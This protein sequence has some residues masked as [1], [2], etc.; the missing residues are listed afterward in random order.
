MTS[1][2]NSPSLTPFAPPYAPVPLPSLPPPP[3]TPPGAVAR[4][5]PEPPSAAAPGRLLAAAGLAGL[6]A[7]TV[8]A[9]VRPG[10]GVPLV[11]LAVAVAVALGGATVGGPVAGNAGT[12]ARRLL[13]A[14]C[15]ILTAVAAVRDSAWLV[16]LCLLAAVVLA[17]VAV[18]GARGWA[19]TA[20]A[21][22]LGA[23]AFGSAVGWAR[24]G[25]PRSRPTV[26]SRAW[27]RGLAVGAVAAVVVGALLASADSAFADLLTT[28]S[29]SFDAGTLP[30]RA[31]LLALVALSVLGGVVLRAH[32]PDWAQLHRPTRAGVTAP[33]AAEWA[34]PLALVD[35]VLAA[36]VVLQGDL[37]GAAPATPDG[38]L[39]DRAR[40]GFGQLV[41]VTLLTT[42]LLVW[43]V[44][45]ASPRRSRH[46]LAVAVLGGGMVALTL[47]VV[48]SAL[49]RLWRYEQAYGW[50][51]LRLLVGLG[52]LWL[53]AVLL[54]VAVLWT[55][56]RLHLV[57][58]LV[59]GSAA[60]CLAAVALAG[61][62][63]LVARANVDRFADTGRVDVRY[64]QRLSADAVPELD[65]L[66]EPLRSCVLDAWAGPR[67]ADADAWSGT[68]LARV[69][70][71]QVLAERPPTP[72]PSGCGVAYVNRG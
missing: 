55:A 26:A 48:A 45:R 41:A 42:A 44:R 51:V 12:G 72:L 6:L 60:V 31:V 37:L 35:L 56:R 62:D 16:W 71:R 59:V 17:P 47:A 23:V 22:L 1:P 68:N 9:D 10:V 69:R 25:L 4:L 57:A 33:P 63:A 3:P 19:A 64:L 40:Q 14:V 49:G 70:A 24:R 20:V 52:E 39:A 29:P 30:A 7:A 66:R 50:T 65:R 28:L 18:T 2:P 13:L 46:R 43:C 54:L 27:L 67:A 34:L 11:A 53:G 32:R 38:A 15:L 8:L 58:P 36:F 61:P 5:R 21:P